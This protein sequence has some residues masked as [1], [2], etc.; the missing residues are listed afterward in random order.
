MEIK[1][2]GQHIFQHDVPLIAVSEFSNKFQTIYST[3]KLIV[4]T[5]LRVCKGVQM[6]LSGYPSN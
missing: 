3:T 1:V 5:S 4:F 6:K 2:K